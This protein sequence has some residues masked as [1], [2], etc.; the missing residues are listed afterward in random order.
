MSQVS[1]GGT[2]LA[3]VTASAKALRPEHEW[4]V[5]GTLTRSV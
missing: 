2:I 3:E 1:L 4:S 5:C